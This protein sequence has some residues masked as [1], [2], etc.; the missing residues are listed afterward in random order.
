M[1]TAFLI[2]LLLA[3]L[4]GTLI[5]FAVTSKDDEHAAYLFG[6]IVGAFLTATGFVLFSQIF[7]HVCPTIGG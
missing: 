4:V 6:M 5:L 3:E 7:P 2:V 1:V